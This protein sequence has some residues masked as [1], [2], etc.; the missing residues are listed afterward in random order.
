MWIRSGAGVVD[1]TADGIHTALM[2]G[3]AISALAV[4]VALLVRRPPESQTA[5]AEPVRKTGDVAVSAPGSPR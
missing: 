3:G 1:A 4:L 5:T 2:Y